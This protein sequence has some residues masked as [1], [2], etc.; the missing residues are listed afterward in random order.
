[1]AD[2]TALRLAR[3]RGALPAENP[4]ARGFE[5]VARNP[6]CQRLLALTLVGVTPATAV[7]R[8]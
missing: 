7:A 8:G 4:G 3:L 6:A 5:R 2:R 1:M